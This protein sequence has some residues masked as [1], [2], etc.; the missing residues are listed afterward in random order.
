V[1]LPQIGNVPLVQR[2]LPQASLLGAAGLR[3]TKSAAAWQMVVDD[4]FAGVGWCGL[5]G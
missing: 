2:W 4:G 3:C 1:L 5:P